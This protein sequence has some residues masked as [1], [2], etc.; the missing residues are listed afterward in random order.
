MKQLIRFLLVF[1]LGVG[2]ALGYLAW[3]GRAEFR[4]DAVLGVEAAL[5]SR[6][7]LRSRADRVRQRDGSAQIVLS[8]ADLEALAIAAIADHDKG[9][10]L[11]RVVREV[12]A[13]L[14]ED[15]LELGFSV[16]VGALER[17]G[18]VETEMLERVL[19]ILPLLRGRNFYVGFRG[20]PGA[21][22][23]KIAWVEDL[24]VT[25]GFLTLP[26]DDLA[27]KLGLSTDAV[28]SQ[29]K[30]DIGGLAVDEIQAGKDQITLEVQVE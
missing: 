20:V 3:R 24:E 22:N 16:D 23:G 7:V 14:E 1:F 12:R 15:S 8:E 26:V 2:A 21:V 29:V 10:D 25:L 28:Y 6:D 17:S 4:E 13:D 19:D 5:E 18:L 11:V 30:L 27:E 9:A